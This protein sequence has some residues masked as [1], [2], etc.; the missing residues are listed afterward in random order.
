MNTMT[1]PG[2]TAG[3]S[4]YASNGRYRWSADAAGP[5]YGGDAL[6]QPALRF[7]CSMKGCCLDLGDFGLSKVCCT[8]DGYCGSDVYV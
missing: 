8:S 7:Y 1:M 2:F 5:R 6:V 4:V 3:A